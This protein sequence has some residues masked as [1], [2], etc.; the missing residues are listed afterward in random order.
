MHCCL[1]QNLC[2]LIFPS[3]DESLQ[4]HKPSINFI[5]L[6]GLESYHQI[7]VEQ[8]IEIIRIFAQNSTR[9]SL[10]YVGRASLSWSVNLFLSK[11]HDK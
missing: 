2:N 5:P 8:Y 10:I 4:L 7:K 9:F 6:K 1:L 11:Q 3:S